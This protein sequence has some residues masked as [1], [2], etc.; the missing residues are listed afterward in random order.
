MPWWRKKERI[1]E[2]QIKKIC[3]STRRQ[4]KRS[5]FCGVSFVREDTRLAR[6]KFVRDMTQKNETTRTFFLL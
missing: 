4:K 1:Y 6:L 2:S 3:S 5:V